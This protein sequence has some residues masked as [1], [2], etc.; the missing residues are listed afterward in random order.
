MH[1]TTAL[2]GNDIIA[3]KT[4]SPCDDAK[5]LGY[6]TQGN[7]FTVISREDGPAM[8]K[9]LDKDEGISEHDILRLLSHTNIVKL[10]D[11]YL[12]NEQIH[13]ELEY[14]RFTLEEILGVRLDL[15]RKHIQ[16][17]ASSVLFSICFFLSLI[18]PDISS[19]SVYFRL[20]INT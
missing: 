15:E 14:S 4:E 12:Y 16:H 1:R 6:L 3:I 20:Q 11:A 17:I 8:V 7:K 2:T 10:R 18:I 19:H 5:R 13:L 9:V